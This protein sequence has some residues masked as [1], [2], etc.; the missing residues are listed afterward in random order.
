MV[1][2]LLLVTR[3]QFLSQPC[4]TRLLRS[5]VLVLVQ[6]QVQVQLQVQV[7]VMRKTTLNLLP[8]C[9]HAVHMYLY[10]WDGE[11]EMMVVVV[12]VVVLALM[13]IARE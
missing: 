5:K 6:V 1:V 13:Q 2:V 10:L 4:H 12:A 7:I 11:E 8:P 3:F 9:C